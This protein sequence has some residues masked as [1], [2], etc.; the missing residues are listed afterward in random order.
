MSEVKKK[1]KELVSLIKNT[2][3]FSKSISTQIQNEH[4]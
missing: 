1:K 3:R 2:M 4:I